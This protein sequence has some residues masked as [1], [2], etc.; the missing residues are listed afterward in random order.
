MCPQVIG[1]LLPDLLF[2]P[3]VDARGIVFRVIARKIL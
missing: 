1:G 3:L 2:E